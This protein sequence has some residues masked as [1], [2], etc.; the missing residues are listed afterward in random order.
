MRKRHEAQIERATIL[1]KDATIKVIRIRLL[2]AL[3]LIGSVVAGS[4]SPARSKDFCKAHILTLNTKVLLVLK[5]PC[6]IKRSNNELRATGATA[7]YNLATGTE[8]ELGNK[9]WALD[10]KRG[11]IS[12]DGNETPGGVSGSGWQKKQNGCWGRDRGT[13]RGDIFC[14]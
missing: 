10:L 12:I 4:T 7:L 1:S 9:A 8:K 11:I 6:A 14:L 2:S 13:Q 5:E 3:V